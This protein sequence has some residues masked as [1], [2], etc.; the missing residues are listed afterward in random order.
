MMNRNESTHVLIYFVNSKSLDLNE[1]IIFSLSCRLQASWV[2]AS[3]HYKTILSGWV[4]S[5][6]LPN[7]YLF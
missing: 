6:E 4:R 3:S 1:M 5:Q 2:Q 7:S